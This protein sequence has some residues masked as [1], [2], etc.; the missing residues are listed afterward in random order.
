MWSESEILTF[1]KKEIIPFAQKAKLVVDYV[2]ANKDISK[3]ARE[4]PHGEAVLKALGG[5]D[6]ALGLAVR[7]LPYV[8]LA[9]QAYDAY[10][11]FGGHPM[12]PSAPEWRDY[13]KD[14]DARTGG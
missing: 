1:T 6:K 2:V 12:D 5:V 13:L 7:D 4:I 9:F 14:Y 11:G 10:R 3:L 8:G